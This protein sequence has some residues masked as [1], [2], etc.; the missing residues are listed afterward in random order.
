MATKELMQQKRP[1][2]AIPARLNSNSMD[3]RVIIAAKAFHSIVSLV[4][5]QDLQPVIIDDPATDMAQFDGLV[6]PGGGDIDPE[7]YG[8]SQ[9]PQVYDVNPNQDALDFNV[10]SSALT[11]EIPILGIC[12]GMQ[13]LNSLFGGTLHQDLQPTKTTHRIM[14]A[15][16][17]EWSW[18]RVALR[19]GSPLALASGTKTPN[20]AS[21]H[22]QG[23]DR[24]GHGLILEGTA[25]DGLPEAFSTTNGLIWAVQWHPEAEGTEP[26]VQMA[27]FH[28]FADRVKSEH[29]GADS[30]ARPEGLQPAIA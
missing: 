29:E 18:H 22:H 28:L 6:L 24:L 3:A 11:Q 16:V 23:I 30:C 1:R 20:I 12:R 14:S 15:D 13:I 5:S 17:A 8:Q 19:S 4:E 26:L 10:A 2:V 25:P 27:P 9:S 21:A 7:R